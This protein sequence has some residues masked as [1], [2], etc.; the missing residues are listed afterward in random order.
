MAVIAA[1]GRASAAQSATGPS[2]VKYYV[3][4]AAYQGKPENLQEIA[5]RFL[6]STARSQEIFDLNVGVLQPDGGKL[7]DPAVLHAGW[8]L[9]LPWD[10]VGAGVHYGLLPKVA[11]VVPKPPPIRPAQAPLPVPP[12]K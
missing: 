10:A 1:A 6:G 5:G 3:V 11:P 9:V 4:A 12:V 8:D 7:T 2:N